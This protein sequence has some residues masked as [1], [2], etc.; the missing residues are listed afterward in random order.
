VNWH[1]KTKQGIQNF[2]REDADARRGKDPG[3]AQRDL[4]EAIARGDFAKR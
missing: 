3:F 2:T 1:F 4:S